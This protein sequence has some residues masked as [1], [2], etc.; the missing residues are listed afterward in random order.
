MLSVTE[1]VEKTGRDGE[2]IR[3]CR[4][5]KNHALKR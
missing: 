2:S 1:A 3:R 5:S 4:A